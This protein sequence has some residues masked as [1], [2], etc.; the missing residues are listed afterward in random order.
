MTF[1]IATASD[2]PAL[3][4]LIADSVRG[5]SADYYT[6][7]Q[8]DA[9]LIEVFGVDTQLIEDETYYVMDGTNGPAAA[10]GWSGRR[11]LFG[12]S[13]MKQSDDPRLDPAT[14]PARIRA[15]FVHPDYARR[16][17][18][19]ELYNTCARAAYSAGFRTFEL[20]ATMPGR[21]LYNALGFVEVEHVQLP[22]T[23]NETLPLTRMRRVIEPER[24]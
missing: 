6:P 18:A 20:M 15:F 5:L 8:I 13:H 23:N 12:G 21:P 19:R 9:S 2:I 14:E 1:R 16:G 22:M 10:G 7:A 24:A 4:Q 17:L 11:T 3:Q